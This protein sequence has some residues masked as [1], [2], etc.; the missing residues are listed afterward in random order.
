MDCYTGVL[1]EASQHYSVINLRFDDILGFNLRLGCILDEALLQVLLPLKD[2]WR[3][4][5]VDTPCYFASTS[6]CERAFSE[7]L[8]C[9]SMI[10]FLDI[11]GIDR[12]LSQ[13]FTSLP[14]VRECASLRIGRTPN[15]LSAVEI[16]E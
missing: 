1:P 16:I 11:D 5:S 8:F 10:V 6:L 4:G 13:P 2:A 3:H 7:L 12:P 14:A 9:E 15:P